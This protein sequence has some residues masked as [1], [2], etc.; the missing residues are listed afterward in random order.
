MVPAFPD[1]YQPEFEHDACGV[2]M[3]CRID[4]SPSHD[5]IDKGLKILVRLE[6][7]G[8]VGADPATGDG[9]GIMLQIPHAFLIKEARALGIQ[10]PDPGAYAVGT[11][12]VPRDRDTTR[13]DLRRAA[14]RAGLKVLGWRQVPVHT[15]GLGRASLESR[16]DIWQVFLARP[17]H[18]DDDLA[19]ARALFVARRL[20]ESEGNLYFCGLSATTIVYKGQLTEAQL[21]DFYPDLQDPSMAS[22][23]ALVH[24]R[25][26]TN[27]FPRWPL[28]QPFRFLAH[29]GEINTLRGNANWMKAREALFQT[30]VFGEHTGV[31]HQ[32]LDRSGSDSLQLDQALELML[33]TG[34]SLPQSVMT[35]L[36]EAWEHNDGMEAGRRAF[37]EYTA[38]HM[39]P[40]DGPAAVLFS[41]GRHAGAVMDR[42]GLRPV[43][44][45]VTH[46]GYMIVASEAGPLDIE[47][48][49]VQH[50]GRLQPG[51][52]LLVD[53]QEGRLIEDEEIKTHVAGGRP[54][55]QWLTEH[56]RHVDT[57]PEAAVQRPGH[58]ADMVTLWRRFGYTRESLEQ[59]VAP[60]AE[61]GKEPIASMGRDIPLAVLSSQP[62]P[63]FDYFKQLFAQ[64]T[65]PPLDAIREEMVTSLF[66]N[67]GAAHNLFEEAPEAARLVRL[68]TP[69]ISADTLN[70]LEHL[71][72]T[73][74]LSST[75]PS[76]AD[77]DRLEAALEDLRCAASRAIEDGRDIL[78]LSDRVPGEGR[79]PLPTLLA[80]GAVHHH[81]IRTGRRMRCS[82]VVDS[83]EPREVHHCCTLLGYGA[84]AV[85]PWLAVRSAQYL[86]EQARIRLPDP[87]E[88]ANRLLQALNASVLKVMSKMGISTVQ[89]YTGAQIFEAVGV[90][91]DVVADAFVGTPSRIGGIRLDDIARDYGVYHEHA[92]APRL[93]LEPELPEGG[94]QRWRRSGEH[95][96]LRPEVVASLQQS[97]RDGSDSEYARFAELVN[98]QS[99]KL[100]AL[101]GLMEFVPGTPVPLEEVEPWTEIVTRFKTGAMS[102]GSLSGEAHATLAEAMNRIGGRSNTGEGGEDPERYARAHP[103]RSRIKQV[104]SGRFGVTMPYLASADE[105]QIKMAQGAKPGEGGQLPGE[106]VYPWIARTRYS[107]PYVGLISPPP[108][109]D[110]YSIEDLAQ[111]IFD[112]RN[113][114]PDA[115]I[116]VKLVSEAGVGTVAAGVAKAKADVVL[117]S[118]HDGGTGASPANSILH[119]GLPWE[120]GLS[121]AHQTLVRNGLRNR[122]RVE[123]DGGL[124]TG[125]DVAIAAML[126]ADEFGF[127]TIPLVAMGC[128]MMRK[129][130]LNTCPVGVATQNPVLRE[131]FNGLPEH[132]VNYFHFVAEEL[133]SIMAELGVRTVRELTGRVELLR[134][135]AE[136]PGRAARV[137][138]TRVLAVPTADPRLQG[139]DLPRTEDLLAGQLDRAWLRE[140]AC[141]IE[142]GRPVVLRANLDN[143]DRTVGTIISNRLVNLPRPPADDAVTLQ[144]VGTAGQ[145]F[146]AFGTR[147][148]RAH[149]TGQANDYMGKGLCG[150]HVII[151]PP[152]DVGFR[153]HEQIAVGN[154]ALYGATAGDVFIRGRAGERFAVRNSGV[155]AVVEGV[156][157]HGCEYMT[158]GRVVILGP[159]G[160]N[161][162][163]GMSGGVAYVLDGTWDFRQGRCTG[164]G[165]DLESL[166]DPEDI[167]ELRAMVEAHLHWTRS[168]V[169][170]WVLDNWD[171]AL[172]EFVKVMPLEYRAAL[173]R[174]ATEAGEQVAA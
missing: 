10:L 111:L 77:G 42:N 29:N 139:F 117:I 57:L 24:S 3:V 143:T 99:R 61:K 52:M 174:L 136:A 19:F 48:A 89:S 121:E 166:T 109:H 91:P 90:H 165:V 55:G 118:G 40:W 101:R 120:L 106:K 82:L 21:R 95:H 51:R 144:L 157:D 167:S 153:P 17:E 97:V 74:V 12:F 78:V 26:S 158:G 98:D 81:L 45:T 49:N 53:L 105:I 110:I 31:L 94:T 172:Q 50:N 132:V 71:E 163:A 15:E 114:N 130:H 23:M 125:R 32:I 63:L 113:A 126:G 37:Y 133:R 34:R 16:P 93:P 64:V 160:R 148:L 13:R 134:Q 129:C 73:E 124:R 123:C 159:T 69:V 87:A 60:M 127:S 85:H 46:D 1:L 168:A 140:A 161:F 7:R 28:A 147:G 164:D 44:Y 8:A 68:D 9:S 54:Y 170:Q 173:K 162:A 43:R 104:A 70:R 30:E 102:Y 27:T 5:V 112:L 145:S 88:A 47:A 135:R 72:R 92:T 107:T 66:V 86:A 154:V 56:M 169:A 6:H 33:L 137:D 39:E 20:A 2:G 36:P 38:C 67:L 83:G 108:H 80:V 59:L 35:L 22:A 142:A 96:V 146:C 100:G 41:D 25:F 149:L 11:V 155:N 14:E 150:A 122:V 128:I 103:A 151:A 115:R 138:L 76:G 116:S 65:N 84:N 79:V 58:E 75:M 141:D 18:C 119:A 171:A 4:G 62:R 131:R 156:G 152:D